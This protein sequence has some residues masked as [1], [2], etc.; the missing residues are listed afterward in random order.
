MNPRAPSSRRSGFLGPSL[1]LGEVAGI[2][3]RVHWSFALL[4]AWVAFSHF[5]RSGSIATTLAGLLFVLV[6]FGCVV[7]HELGHSLTALRFGIRTRSITLSPIG[8]L[9]AFESFPRNWR[10]ELLVT[11]AGPAVNAVIAALVLP[12]VLLAAPF[13]PVF[14]EPFS[15]TGNFLFM[16]LAANVMLTAFN[17]IPAFPM[18]GG[19]ILRALLAA[20][21]DRARATHVAART[22]QAF[23]VLLGLA[24]LFLSP[25]LVLIAVFVFLAAEAERRSVLVEEARTGATV[26]DVMRHSFETVR[27]SDTV[28]EAVRRALRTGQHDLPVMY[29]GAL[30]RIVDLPT[31][32][33][34]RARGPGDARV[35]E[36]VPADIAPVSPCDEL[37]RIHRAM[38]SRRTAKPSPWSWTVDSWDG[39]PADPCAPSFPSAPRP[40]TGPERVPV[41]HHRRRQRG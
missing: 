29:D 27:H 5:T 12:V 41:W 9:A 36:I 18:D 3:I 37:A 35:A 10:Q 20:R 8:G 39:F 22:G 34:A 14:V 17:L 26:S 28:D 23:A 16:I 30:Q 25:F 32:I 4:L 31:L 13:S 15:T 40:D 2:P 24:G 19:R 7:L 11:L 6:I 33:A 38:Q 21:G 1:S